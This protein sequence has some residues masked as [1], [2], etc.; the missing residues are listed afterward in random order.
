VIIVDTS[1][2]I[3]HIRRPIDALGELLL[4]DRIRHHPFVTAEIMLG[5]VAS[6]AAVAAA[7]SRLPACL[8]AEP[9]ALLRFLE[10]AELSGCGIGFVDAHLLLAAASAEHRLWTRDKRLNAHAERLDLAYPPA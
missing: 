10:S 9:E 1:V 7:L 6:R 4:A 3:D 2:W 8:P 5:S